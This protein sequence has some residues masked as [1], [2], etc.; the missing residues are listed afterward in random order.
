MRSIPLFPARSWGWPRLRLARLHRLLLDLVF[1]RHL[2]SLLRMPL[3]YLLR[4]GRACVGMMFRFLLLLEL[5][6]LL[7]LPGDQ[8]GLLLF[9]LLVCLRISRVDRRGAAD[10][11]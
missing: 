1:L 5:L 7:G 6:P 8:I 11:G 9:V 2:L 3:L 4:L 10:C